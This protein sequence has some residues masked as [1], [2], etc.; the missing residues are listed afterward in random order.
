MAVMASALVT[1]TLGVVGITAA[2]ATV[3]SVAEY[4]APA[5]DGGVDVG[6][7]TLASKPCATLGYALTQE[8]ANAADSVGSV[9]NLAKGTYNSEGVGDFF[10]VL[11][12]TNS[13]V[14]ISG[15]TKKGAKNASVIEPQTCA[16]LATASSAPLPYTGSKAIAALNTGDNGITIENLDLNGSDISSCPGYYTGVYITGGTTGDAV[17]Q[18]LIQSGA[19]NGVLTDDNADSTIISNEVGSVNQKDDKVNEKS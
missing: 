17:V 12:T 2:H 3:N 16:Q 15:S 1:G 10:N 9:I 11:A 14:T 4:V 5:G 18:D 13:N 19:Y 7:C 6:N 8:A